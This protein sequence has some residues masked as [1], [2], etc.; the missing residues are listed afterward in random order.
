MNEEKFFPAVFSY[1]ALITVFFSAHL[2]SDFVMKVAIN[3]T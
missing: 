3:N 1:V 2:F